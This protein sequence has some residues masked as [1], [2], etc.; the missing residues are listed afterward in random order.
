MGRWL[1]KLRYAEKNTETALQGTDKTPK[2]P[3]A[4]FLGVLGAP[5]PSV[6][7]IFSEAHDDLA[8]EAE[9]RAATLEYDAGL[10]RMEAERLAVGRPPTPGITVR[11]PAVELPPAEYDRHLD[12][13]I[14]A[15]GAGTPE[16]SRLAYAKCKGW[17]VPRGDETVFTRGR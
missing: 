2:N 11:S 7:A 14:A 8:M 5:D 15:A 1:A 10:P 6:S 12:A 17:V 9:E 4:P 13:L 3:N 16:G